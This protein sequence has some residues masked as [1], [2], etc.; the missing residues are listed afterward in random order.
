MPSLNSPA[1]ACEL[2]SF[3][4]N[5]TGRAPSAD[6]SDMTVRLTQALLVSC[7]RPSVQH[8]GRRVGGHSFR[9]ADGIFRA[10]GTNNKI[11][12]KR[13]N[14]KKRAAVAGGSK[15]ITG[16]RQTEWTGATRRPEAG[17]GE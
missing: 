15:V 10:P 1:K 12:E 11:N 8:P 5:E 2:A 6:I 16:R 13:H 17:R 14:A 4:L 3:S 7:A 9:A